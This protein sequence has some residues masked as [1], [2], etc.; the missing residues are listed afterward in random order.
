M[1]LAY[2]QDV[3]WLRAL[4]VVAVVGF[5]WE[6]SG[7]RG[8][9]VGVDVFFV[10]SG[11]LIGRIVQSE[12]AT[13]A[14]SFTEFYVRRIRRLVPALYVM[15]VVTAL[16]GNVVL[17]DSELAEF[18]RSV[19][20]VATFSSNIF[21]WMQSG[22]FDRAGAEK[23]L[24]HTWS[25]GIEEQFYILLPILLYLLWKWRNRLGGRIVVAA[26]AVASYVASDLLLARESAAGFFLLQSR[27]WELLVGVMLV[28]LPTLRAAWAGH[29]A[30]GI[31]LTMILAAVLSYTPG[32][33]AAHY[34]LL[35]VFGAAIFILGG[36]PQWRAPPIEFVG[37]MSYSLY[38]WHWP[39]YTLA[40]LNSPTTTL[41]LQLKLL[42]AVAFLV[43][44]YASYRLIE[45][46]M[47]QAR[48][49]SKTVFQLAAGAT[50]AMLLV[51]GF[52]LYSSSGKT[53]DDPQVAKLM[54]YDRYPG[55]VVRPPCFD[56]DWT[57]DN[58]PG[59]IT[60]NGNNRSVLVWGDSLA[61][62]YLPGLKA[63][64]G[65]GVDYSQASGVGCYP[66]VSP[67]ITEGYCRHLL[68]RV[69][70][71]M[72]EGGGE[73]TLLI[74]TDW[75]NFAHRYG[76]DTMMHELQSTI[77]LI[78]GRI[79]VLGP[80]VRFKARLPPLLLRARKRGTSL[81]AVDV[82]DPV[83]FDLDDK[84]RVAFEKIPGATYLSPMQVVCPARQCKLTVGD[85]DP[86]TWDH[87]HMT[88][89]GSIEVVRALAP[90]IFK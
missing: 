79:F 62:H 88:V 2:R 63:L 51:F 45:K 67:T 69:T 61:D 31:G 20:A 14:F 7:F 5:H 49:S 89:A 22:Y 16:V 58:H 78:G 47:R 3:D 81:A 57:E 38:L 28:W 40:K 76:F 12:I 87:G 35:P 90:A 39:I 55:H 83:S 29:V 44:S 72:H 21:F 75:V 23:P 33:H 46:P 13:G 24:L 15:I 26:I 56:E 1:T 59:C 19:F 77:S 66:A 11:F 42:L 41:P 36:P 9:Y 34:A 17:L 68:N 60:H 6:L 86:I 73:S 30:R 18:R 80:S 10:I 65:E 53:S 32:L 4:A 71:F 85:G 70:N 27:A 74:S 54:E 64:G 52:A 48:A 84:M 43:V 8:G 37:G 82:V 50:A 25:L